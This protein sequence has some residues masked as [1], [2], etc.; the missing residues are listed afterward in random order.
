MPG[1]WW[2]WDSALTFQPAH[3]WWLWCRRGSREPAACWISAI[4]GASRWAVTAGYCK[5]ALRAGGV[6][7]LVPSGSRRGCQHAPNGQGRVRGVGWYCEHPLCVCQG[8]WL[9]DRAACV[10]AVHD[11]SRLWL[12]ALQLLLSAVCLASWH[13]DRCMWLQ[14]V[15][16]SASARG[17]VVWSV[18]PVQEATFSQGA[19]GGL[20]TC[21]HS[22]WL[23]HLPPT[24]C[25]SCAGKACSTLALAGADPCSAAV[26]AGGCWQCCFYEH[27]W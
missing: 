10:C 13:Q 23:A 15:S 1:G 5:A 19:R 6:T 7:E 11:N 26:I 16:C 9:L 17:A 24:S 14:P 4:T 20:N 25:F 3:R 22:S 8:V 18:L 21:A 12:D 2:T 27:W